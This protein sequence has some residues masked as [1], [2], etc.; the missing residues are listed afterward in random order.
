MFNESILKSIFFNLFCLR[1]N[2]MKISEIIV[3]VLEVEVVALEVETGADFVVHV[4]GLD[5]GLGEGLHGGDGVAVLVHAGQGTL[6]GDTGSEAA[7]VAEH[8]GIAFG[9]GL[10]DAVAHVGDHTYD[11]ALGVD[12]VVVSHVS[13]EA[14]DVEDA[15]QLQAG[16]R[17][18]GFIG[19]NGVLLHVQRVLKSCLHVM[20]DPGP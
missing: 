6:A 15:I 10:L 12:A 11:H 17:L 5:V 9:D 13:S 19:M 1:I 20:E 16:V 2:N 3:S 18:L 14:V 7:Q 8:Y 4:H